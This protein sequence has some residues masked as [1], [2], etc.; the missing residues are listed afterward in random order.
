MYTCLMNSYWS[1][2]PTRMMDSFQSFQGTQIQV[3]TYIA[4]TASSRSIYIRNEKFSWMEDIRMRAGVGPTGPFLI[5][6]W[7]GLIL[8]YRKPPKNRKKKNIFFLKNTHT[9]LLAHYI[10]EVWWNGRR[11]CVSFLR[12]QKRRRNKNVFLHERKERLST[13]GVVSSLNWEI[14]DTRHPHTLFIPPLCHVCEWKTTAPVPSVWELMR[15]RISPWLVSIRL[16]LSYS[17]GG[18]CN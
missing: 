10:R 8:W 11:R 9:Q 7:G 13:P 16:W 14:R 6:R 2:I 15:E 4:P 18:V 12:S 1:I 3:T 17:I 5:D